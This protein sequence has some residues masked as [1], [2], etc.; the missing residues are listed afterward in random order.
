MKHFFDFVSSNDKEDLSNLLRTAR[1]KLR[2][3]PMTVGEMSTKM[4]LICFN[5]GSI[6][7]YVPKG[8][9]SF[10]IAKNVEL[11][12]H[13]TKNTILKI[14]QSIQK[15]AND[16][17]GYVLENIQK[18]GVENYLEI[19]FHLPMDLEFEPYIVAHFS[20][21]DFFAYLDNFIKT[22]GNSER[23]IEVF[24]SDLNKPWQVI[25]ESREL[26]QVDRRI[27][28]PI[29]LDRPFF[30]EI[31][32]NIT[33][34]KQN[35]AFG[36]AFGKLR[37]VL[38]HFNKQRKPGGVTIRSN[39][40]L[41][42]KPKDI[43]GFK[44][45]SSQPKDFK[46]ISINGKYI[47]TSEFI[48]QNIGLNVIQSNDIDFFKLSLGRSVVDVS[49][50]D[51][52]V[53]S[54]NLDTQQ[55]AI[56][57]GIGENDNHIDRF[58]KLKL[59]KDKHS[60]V[61]HKFISFN[62]GESNF[63]VVQNYFATKYTEYEKARQLNKFDAEF[64]LLVRRQIV[65]GD[66]MSHLVLFAMNRL[67]ILPFE[68][69]CLGFT[70]N[71][72]KDPQKMS[73]LHKKWLAE[74]FELYTNIL[75]TSKTP[76]FTDNNFKRLTKTI[77][78][79]IKKKDKETLK[80]DIFEKIIDEFESLIQYMDDFFK[81][82][83]YNK[84]KDN[85]DIE[86]SSTQIDDSAKE[87]ISSLKE[88]YRLDDEARDFIS[89]N[90]T[91][92]RKRDLVNKALI[93]TER[94]LFYSKN[95]Q[96]FITNHNYEPDVV[97]FNQ[98]DSIIKNYQTTAY[99]ALNLSTLFR[100]GILS[101]E[102]EDDEMY[103]VK[104]MKSFTL[105]VLK[106][107][108]TLSQTFHHQYKHTLSELKLNAEENL[109]HLKNE[110]AFIE[111]PKNKEEIYQKLLEKIIELFHQQLDIKRKNISSLENELKEVEQQ[112]EKNRHL[113]CSLLKINITIDQLA[114][115][116]P[117]MP[118]RLEAIK[119]DI[120]KLKIVKKSELSTI[121][122]PYIKFNKA[123]YH[124]FE[125]SIDHL[126]ILKK[127]RQNSTKNTLINKIN[128]NLPD[129][130]SLSQ[131]KLTIKYEAL[132][133]P[134]KNNSEFKKL[135][136]EI[137]QLIGNQTRILKQLKTDEI[138]KLFQ[139]KKKES[140]D[141]TEYLRYFKEE[142]Q[143]LVSLI[144]K[145]KQT[146]SALTKLQTTLN[147]KQADLDAV[148]RKLLQNQLLSQ[149]YLI[150][151][152]KKEPQQVLA[153]YLCPAPPLPIAETKDEL[154]ALR[155]QLAESLS[156]FQQATSKSK[157][158]KMQS[159]TQIISL[160]NHRD[161]INNVA[162]D[163]VNYTQG[164]DAIKT[165]IEIEKEDLEYLKSQESNLEA[166]A[167][168]KALPSTRIL[169]KT[170]Y[171]PYVEKEISLL[172][173]ADR[174]LTE[175]CSKENEM[176]EALIKT[177]YHQRYG[178]P[179]FLNGY[180]ALDDSRSTKD[181]TEKNIYATYILLADKYA[182]IQFEAKDQVIRASLMKLLVKGIDGLKHKIS[183]LWIDNTRERFIYLPA[184]LSIED[185]LE[186]CE[187]KQSVINENPSNNR[188][189]HSLILIYINKFNYDRIRFTDDLREKYNQAILSNIFIN[190]DGEK[191]FNNRNS[192]YDACIHATFGCSHD[193]VTRQIADQLLQMED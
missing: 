84:H 5:A 118:D 88:T 49:F 187:Y 162:K 106:R 22:S 20:N 63:D 91:F 24:D 26:S 170:Q 57:R 66:I 117:T 90:F 105:K 125:K 176:K 12:Q 142:I 11:D 161:K 36:Y 33:R 93:K 77:G 178:Y 15:D 122:I 144:Q 137:A 7:E 98:T 119:K 52:E 60:A 28:E 157:I 40:T 153:K 39:N 110:L 73:N 159:F 59:I 135:E 138:K 146:Y 34:D 31:H 13:I 166:V 21:E 75:D 71:D 188:S 107:A 120:N 180:F 43:I 182:S 150:I 145:L 167:M 193:R 56:Q 123:L 89:S 155:H 80:P 130:L 140:G 8:M 168:S 158:E 4:Q 174:L 87:E 74:L 14:T 184:T 111:T 79:F 132:K 102:L 27:R 134:N 30:T 129:F 127:S 81:L 47:T 1:D 96:P 23:S 149:V 2:Q 86:S 55:V 169:L 171:I 103:F 19:L 172:T 54:I 164:I 160:L 35:K 94:I 163:L 175:I 53:M 70:P 165:E 38:G 45:S 69:K 143:K 114:D 116:L 58:K 32:L 131:E 67:N 99:P 18:K 85:L 65:A 41:F 16:P 147:Q 156:Q 190:I 104:F 101:N 17:L 61:I 10:I 108:K 181:Y 185:A 37:S 113:L 179:Q 82:N 29:Y 3:A 62:R 72:I 76:Q 109:E 186:L 148:R 42:L 92:F 192:I 173:K 136:Q 115:F 139:N 83:I 112:I 48:N 9:D 46:G 141:M 124:Y 100:Q 128:K 68:P 50:Q 51:V 121:F 44:L 25:T 133:H 151:K 152:D 126:E 189:I 183:Q 191:I 154:N 78:L 95:I 64:Q 6:S 177:F 97:V